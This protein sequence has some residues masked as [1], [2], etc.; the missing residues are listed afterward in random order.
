MSAHPITES[1]PYFTTAQMAQDHKHFADGQFV[2]VKYTRTVFNVVTG[3]DEDL[4][5]VWTGSGD[6]YPS[7][8]F[9]HAMRRFTI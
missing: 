6:K 2:S 9:A 5:N 4:F 7:E 1:A 3:K 8:L